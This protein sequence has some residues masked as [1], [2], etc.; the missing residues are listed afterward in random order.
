[1]IEMCV[2]CIDILLMKLIWYLTVGRFKR[3][4]DQLFGQSFGT[5][6][7]QEILE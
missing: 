3:Y 5:L 4:A 7:V 1:M 6:P 2:V